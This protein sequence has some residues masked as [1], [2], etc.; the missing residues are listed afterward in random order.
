VTRRHLTLAARRSHH[1][2]VREVHAP[3]HE[4]EEHAAPQQIQRALDVANE[5]VLQQD[6]HRPEFRVREDLLEVGETLVIHAI[7]G[8][9]LLL[10]D[11]NR[12]AVGHSADHLPVVAVPAIVAF[13]AG[14]NAA[15]VNRSM[16]F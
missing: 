13:V 6:R 15:G 2:Q 10:H 9:D 5:I 1:H 16:S 12:C 7:H 4:H 8:V 14:A 3:D 11:V